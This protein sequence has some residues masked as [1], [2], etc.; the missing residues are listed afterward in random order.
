[1]KYALFVVGV[2][3]TIGAIWPTYSSPLVTAGEKAAFPP[4]YRLNVGQE[5]CYRSA[6]RMSYS[7]GLGP[8]TRDDQI[9]SKV[10]VARQNSDG[11]WRLILHVQVRNEW[12]VN[13]IHG[14]KEFRPA[15]VRSDVVFFD[16]FPD[17]RIIHNDVADYSIWSAADLFPRLPNDGQA[18]LKGWE[19]ALE[20][21]GLRSRFAPT[22]VEKTANSLW[23]FDEVRE[24]PLDPF[25]Y[26]RRCRFFFHCSHGL[27][28]RAETETIQNKIGKQKGVTELKG[29][30]ARESVWVKRLNDE[31]DLFVAAIKEDHNLTARA[32]GEKNVAL[33]AEAQS[34]V[35]KFRDTLTVSFLREQMDNRIKSQPNLRK[36]Y[37]DD[38]K[39]R[40]EVIG[41][42]AVS[43]EAKDLAGKTHTLRGYRGK[44]VILDFWYRRCL[45]CIKAMPQVVQI[46]H[47]FK[48]E[49]VVVFG[50]NTDEEEADA[51]FVAERLKISHPVLRVGNLFVEYQVVTWPTLIIID[52]S[53]KVHAI[54]EGWSATLREDVGKAIRTLLTKH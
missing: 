23:S 13:D 31:A 54:H 1:M 50:M 38:E 53:G 45:Y 2:V 41:K 29:V 49:P 34:R 40:T 19:V 15:R 27:V 12:W 28:Q 4:R 20:E 26:S 52:Q 18:T 51:Q 17:G 24:N 14:K 35:K 16:L 37:D 44:I 22:P 39:R 48:D 21:E 5:L 9:E 11:S 43:W 7:A 3:L 33:L 32:H 47:D 6:S 30:I 36:R 10:Y 46:A 25:I 42:P 8:S